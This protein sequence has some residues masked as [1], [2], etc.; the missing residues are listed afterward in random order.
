MHMLNFKYNMYLKAYFQYVTFNNLYILMS[1]KRHVSIY[2][3]I[4]ICL[5]L[6][7]NV[8]NIVKQNT[9]F[10]FFVHNI[11]KTT[12]VISDFF[13]GSKTALKCQLCILLALSMIL[14]K[15]FI[16]VKNKKWTKMHF[17][18]SYTCI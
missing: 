12:V 16:H 15:I 17:P 2:I 13:P 9:Q 11:L 8:K 4:A 6:G 18:T 10:L 1:K 7:L 5:L 3:Y 14:Y